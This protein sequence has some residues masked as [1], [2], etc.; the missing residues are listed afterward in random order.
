MSYN[1]F[2]IVSEWEISTDFH[3]GVLEVDSTVVAI[4]VGFICVLLLNKA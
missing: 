4:L 2:R 1:F 3:E